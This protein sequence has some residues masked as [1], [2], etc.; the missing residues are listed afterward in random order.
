MDWRYGMSYQTVID[1]LQEHNLSWSDVDR[2]HLT[3]DEHEE[4]RER[5]SFK[6]ANHSTTNRPAVRVA[7]E[8]ALFYVDR[9]G[10][11]HEIEL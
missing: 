5:A 11:M 6:T 3:E 10:E 2:I 9:A 4:F 1:A 7:Q 8:S